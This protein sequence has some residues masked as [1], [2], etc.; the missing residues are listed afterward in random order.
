MRKSEYCGKAGLVIEVLRKVG[1]MVIVYDVPNE[2]SEKEILK[3]VFRRNLK[4]CMS[5]EEFKERVRVLNG[6]EKKGANVVNVI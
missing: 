1:P 2:M 3:D 5:A 6:G 4:E